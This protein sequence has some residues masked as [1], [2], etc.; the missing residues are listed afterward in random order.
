M[1]ADVVVLLTR[2]L[3][4]RKEVLEAYLFGSTARGEGRASSD[5][6]VAVF[7]DNEE[8]SPSAFGLATDIAT[9]LMAALG[10]NDV[11]VV[12]LNQAPPLLYHRVL[13]D[14]VRLISRD[15]AK[16]T[17]REGQA[18]SRYLD[19]K[20]QLEKMGLL[21]RARLDEGRFGR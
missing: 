4:P 2:A 3:T 1:Q 8:A 14:G 21:Q 7:V 15:L 11:D 12:I 16:T 13:R 17:T 19:F 5:I 20:P 6:D 9:D 18:L 10:R